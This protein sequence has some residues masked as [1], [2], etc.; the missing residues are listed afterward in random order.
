MRRSERRAA[1][2]SG[3]EVQEGR[4]DD[5]VDSRLLDALPEEEDNQPEEQ[6]HAGPSASYGSDSA[7]AQCSCFGGGS[8]TV[9]FFMHVG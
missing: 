5:V 9:W 4:P 8:S 1:Q 3:P 2:R 7:C 6:D